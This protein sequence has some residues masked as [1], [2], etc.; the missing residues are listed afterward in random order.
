[1]PT[2][3]GQTGPIRA[4]VR[5]ERAIAVEVPS[6]G[7]RPLVWFRRVGQ[8]NASTGWRLRPTRGGPRQN[9]RWCLWRASARHGRHLSPKSSRSRVPGA[10]SR[11]SAELT[12][13]S[14]TQASAAPSYTQ[15]SLI[16]LDEDPRLLFGG[17]DVQPN[18]GES[19]GR[20]RPEVNPCVPPAA[21][22]RANTEHL[23][24]S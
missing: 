6:S 1:M 11:A 4:T 10:Q 23:R 13:R 14:R 22:A 19:C 9:S 15:L 18:I 7:Q 16:V 3:C 12:R 8:S 24:E 17:E 20:T 21:V 2:P 5:S